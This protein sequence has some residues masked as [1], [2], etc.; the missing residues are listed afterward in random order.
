VPNAPRRTLLALLAAVA[1]GCG[2]SNPTEARAPVITILPEIAE[3][4]IQLGDTISIETL[5][6][7]NDVDEFLVEVVPGMEVIGYF[8]IL[9]QPDFGGVKFTMSPGAAGKSVQVMDAGP[10]M[11]ENSTEML[12]T[13]SNHVRVRIEKWPYPLRARFPFP[14]RFVVREIDSAP[15]NHPVLVQPGDTIR[16]AIDYT[17][18]YDIFHLTATAGDELTFFLDFEGTSPTGRLELLLRGNGQQNVIAVDT[19]GVRPRDLQRRYSR[20]Q[21]I[22]GGE[23]RIIVRPSLTNEFGL[24]APYRIW[25]NKLDRAPESAPATL[26]PGNAIISES[27][28]VPNDVDEF[29]ID[30]PSRRYLLIESFTD[31]AQPELSVELTDRVNPV[32]VA[33]ASEDVREIA[34]QVSGAT[35]TLTRHRSSSAFPA[36]AGTYKLVIDGANHGPIGYVGPYA[37]RVA[38]IDTTPESVSP[39]LTIG[40]IVTGESIDRNGDIDVFRFHAEK[41]D[42]LRVHF[43]SL[44]TSGAGELL[45]SMLDPLAP[46][47]IGEWIHTWWIPVHPADSVGI[48]PPVWIRRTGWYYIDVRGNEEG[49]NTLEAGP[50]SLGVLRMPT[51][52][53]SAASAL[54]AGVEVQEALDY[55]GDIDEFTFAA[56]PGLRFTVSG[57]LEG[58]TPD[59]YGQRMIVIDVIDAAAD[60]LIAWT[61]LHGGTVTPT[62]PPSGQIIVRIRERVPNSDMFGRHYTYTETGDYRLRLDIID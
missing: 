51:A 54:Q 1:A 30:L 5:A 3:F 29:I 7:P 53:E 34:A 6:N 55:L 11:Q 56:A 16:E 58:E 2:D 44:A 32:S 28:D 25:V 50:Y 47:N 36:R 38:V 33:P 8:E 40:Q 4:R 31:P 10:G 59:T 52:P 43:A 62:M 22:T 17:G 18:D 14:Y 37:F 27:I 45:A 20:R 57:T 15:E 19:G 42:V 61:M 24:K 12:V 39:I 21:Q 26:L 35:S 41:G 23:Y 13:N 9:Q 60:T 48:P 49:S 46:P